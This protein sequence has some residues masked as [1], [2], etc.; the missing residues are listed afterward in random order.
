MKQIKR[1]YDLTDPELILECQDVL[2]SIERDI[3]EFTEW[4]FTPAKKDQFEAAISAFESMN[5]D[6]YL[7]GQQEI[8]TGSKNKVRASAEKKISQVLS[9]VE[10]VW[11]ISS[12]EYDLFTEDKAQSQMSDSDMLRFIDDFADMV[13]DHLADLSGEGITTDTV[14]ALRTLYEQFRKALKTQRKAIKE[15]NSGNNARIKK[16]NELHALLSKHC[17]T[18]KKIW[19]GVDESKYNDYLIYDKAEKKET[20]I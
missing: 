11:G 20:V 2:D 4:G 17:N 14:D 12:V 7:L 15:R 19:Y 8:A 5:S 6:N 18:G 16:G 1:K 13:E 9:A 10:N 3:D